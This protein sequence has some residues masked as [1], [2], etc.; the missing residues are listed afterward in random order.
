MLRLP[1]TVQV[2]LAGS[3]SPA[4]AEALPRLSNPPQQDHAVERYATLEDYV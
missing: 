4:L 3:Y 2:P 1:V